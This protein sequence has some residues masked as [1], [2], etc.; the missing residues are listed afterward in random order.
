MKPAIAKL[1]ARL[2]GRDLESLLEEIAVIPP[3]QLDNPPEG[4]EE[5]YAVT[6][7]WGIIAYFAEEADAFRFRLDLINLILNT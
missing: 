2:S 3:G 1:R 7:D 5:W 6:T 4:L